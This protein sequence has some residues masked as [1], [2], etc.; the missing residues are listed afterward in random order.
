M[1]FTQ[2][3]NEYLM[4]GDEYIGEPWVDPYNPL[5]LPPYTIRLKYID[6]VTPSFTKGTA[7][8]VS[9]SPNI[10][11]LTY[12]NKNWDRLVASGASRDLL[13]ILGASTYEVTSMSGTFDKNVNRP[14]DYTHLSSIAI[15]NTHN[16][17]NMDW[18]FGGQTAATSI[19][20]FDTQNVTS[21]AG[22][23]SM[24][25]SLQTVPLFNTTKVTN[26]DRM[27]MDCIGLKY[28]P[29]FDT[30]NV[31]DMSWMYR[32]CFTLTA[33]PLLNTQNVTAMPYMFS[34]CEKVN[35]GALALYQQASTQENVPRIY[36]RAFYHCGISGAQ[37]SAEL[38]QIPDGWK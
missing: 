7:N 29:V 17:T 20:L 2:F 3:N 15:F 30:S 25:N 14:G 10:W 1:S 24:C 22:A 23:F 28:T 8:Q 13:E 19:P 32:D 16:V 33:V 34:Q 6:G 11:D 31:T 35:A 21:M 9:V 38:A 4:F 37:G 36:G 26:M 12:E 18:I 27:F 5:N